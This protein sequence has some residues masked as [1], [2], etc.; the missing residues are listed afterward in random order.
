MA[1]RGLGL[2]VRRGRGLCPACGAP[3]SLVLIADWISPWVLLGQRPGLNGN[4]LRAGRVRLD[5]VYLLSPP[6]SSFK[7][8]RNS[9]MASC[10]LHYLS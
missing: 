8:L 2:E 10:A 3:G 1:G 6:F 9:S 5:F 4:S 7:L